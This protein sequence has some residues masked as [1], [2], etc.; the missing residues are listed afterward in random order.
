[1]ILVT[2]FQFRS[3]SGGTLTEIMRIKDTGEVGIGTT[4]PSYSLHVK[5]GRILI[6][7]DGS[8]SMLSLQNATAN[9]FSNIVNTGGDSDST[10]AFQVG[11]A[12]S[13]TEAMIIHE[14]GRVGIGVSSPASLLHVDEG[15]IR[16]DT[17]SGATQALR[18][19]ETSTTKAQVQY[20]SGDEEFNLITVDASGT[21]QKRVTIKSEQD[22]T[23]V[24]IGNNS[25][26]QA[27][28]VTGNI[29]VTG[30]VDGRD[31]QTDG[32]KLDGIEA[33]ADVTDTT[34]V[35][36]A[37]SGDLG[38]NYDI[39]NQTSDTA[40]FGGPVK[41]E[42]GGWNGITVENTA[43]T[44]GSHIELKNTE[45]R[46]QVAVRSN[47]FD[48]RDVTASD[49]SRFSINSSGNI[50]IGG[51]IDGRD[52]AT[53]GTKLDGIE[54]SAT[55]DQTAV[56]IIG[57]LNSDLGGNFTIG[58]QSDDS[59]TF[60]GDV[61]ISGDLTVNGG[62]MLLDNLTT[63]KALIIKA[64]DDESAAIEFHAD[65]ASDNQD[66]WQIEAHKDDGDLYFYNMTSGSWAQKFRVTDTGNAVVN[67]ALFIGSV[68]S[69]D[70]SSEN[71]LVFD[72][73]TSRVE[74]RTYA[75]L[76]SDLGIADNE[77]ID[78]TAGSAG[79]I[80][81]SNIPTLNQDTTG[82]AAIATT[83]TV[84]DESS[85]TTCF[86]L[87]A[88]GQTGN[89]AP[90]S[91]SNLTFNSSTGLLS[92]TQLAGDHAA[93]NIGHSG[94]LPLAGAGTDTNTAAEYVALPLGYHGFMHANLGTDEGMPE[95][96]YMFFHK[97]GHRDTD[98]GWGGLAVKYNDGSHAY[99]GTVSDA[100]S[101]DNFA[102]WYKI[103]VQDGSNNVTVDNT[104]TVSTSIQLGHASDT[105]LTR[106]SAGNVNIEGNLVYRAGGTDVPVADGG[107]GQSTLDNLITLGNHTTGN[108][109]A[110]LTAGNLIDV[111]GG[112][113]G[114]TPTIDVDLSEALEAS[115]ADGDYILFLDGGASGDGKKRSFT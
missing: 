85:D 49:T 96:N 67:N 31:L 105:T 13:P 112:A 113:E 102:T 107:T 27:L 63:S 84:A 98:G 28:D 94:N 68:P 15:D 90:K 71:V 82:T 51:T 38:G 110:S 101:G 109:V 10:I 35:L 80:D 114:G 100:T 3:H 91:G 81:A 30:T 5:G 108:Y 58:N 1:M 83:V 77:I 103:L 6:D 18:F 52:L 45:R 39:G 104:L 33:S 87:F 26:A 53:D 14:D 36:S 106:A 70:G 86:P 19:S 62:D 17:A 32:T 34:N 66:K 59:A 46:F 69:G 75:E 54:S 73:G 55:A 76:R 11:E 79:T 37:L 50:T 93:T 89:L 92:A 9:R 88:T 21:A 61:I 47:G 99:F 41:V 16:I 74:K 48:I 29:A 23:A 4:S 78:W 57:L 24:G 20:R 111:G 2:F 72:S 8:N 12:G 44:N 22:A 40:T 60:S 97:F 7:G 25:P 65:D 43:N 56:E 42:H 64:S 115:I 95:N